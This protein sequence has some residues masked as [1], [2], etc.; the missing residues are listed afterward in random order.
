MRRRSTHSFKKIGNLGH[1][2]TSTLV[3]VTADSNIVLEYHILQVGLFFRVKSTYHHSSPTGSLLGRLRV[4]QPEKEAKRDQTV[5]SRLPLS[6]YKDELPRQFEVFKLRVH[7]LEPTP[8]RCRVG[9]YCTRGMVHLPVFNLN[10]YIEINT[11]T[12]ES[13][14]SGAIC[15]IRT[16][17]HLQFTPLDQSPL[18][19]R[20]NKEA[21]KVW[22]RTKAAGNM[23]Q[24]PPKN[25]NIGI[26]NAIMA[27]D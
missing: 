4:S 16:T 12:N 6:K 7:S 22:L 26:R 19:P 2:A 5:A 1:V 9:L 27:G 18:Q 3:P 11:N 23:I 24:H 15:T 17:R 20:G 14:R 8:P 10:V 13:F 25:Y 21:H